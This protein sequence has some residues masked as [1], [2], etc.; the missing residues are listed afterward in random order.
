[1][2]GHF[3]PKAAVKPVKARSRP[4]TAIQPIEDTFDSLLVERDVRGT[5]VVA[6]QHSCP[7]VDTPRF[8]NLSYKRTFEV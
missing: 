3:W 2:K 5:A 1:M 7:G 4:I 6:E 8:R